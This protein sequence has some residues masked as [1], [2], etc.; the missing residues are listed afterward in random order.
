MTALSATAG[1]TTR[2]VTAADHRSNNF[3]ALRL[4]GALVVMFA[5]AFALMA[6]PEEIPIVLGYPLQTIGVII[7]FAIS[8]YLITASFDRNRNPV[9][10]LLARSLRIFPALIVVVLL[11]AFVLG[12]LVTVMPREAFLSEQGTWNYVTNNIR[13]YANFGLPG[14]WGDLP[15]PAA[16]NGSL[17]TL[18]VEFLC[19]LA[20][21]LLFAFPRL[22]RPFAAI[23]A[24]FLAIHWAEADPVESPLFYMVR[25]RDAAGLWIFFAGGAFIRFALQNWSWFR[26]RTDV[27][28]AMVAAQTVIAWCWPDWALETGWLTLSY[29]VLTIGLARTPYVARTARFGDFSYGLYLYAFPVQQLVIDQWGVRGTAVNFVTVLAITSVFAVLSW[30]LIERPALALKDRIL[31]RRVRAGASEPAP[32]QVLV[33]TP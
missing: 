22:L 26:L 30:H 16:V 32:E 20:A 13:L 21:P 3:D 19:Y 27:A 29:A 17:W 8:G 23:A 33:A 6:R 15:Y 5:H 24:A 14:V 31:G 28:V 25:L 2:P 12:P 4:I 1:A 9:T 10:Y 7:F 11:T 18:F